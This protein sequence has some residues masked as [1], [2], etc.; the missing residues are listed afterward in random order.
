MTKNNE[1]EDGDLDNKKRKEIK[2]F[3]IWFN[4]TEKQNQEKRK[5]DL[6]RKRELEQV[7]TKSKPIKMDQK[8]LD[9][10]NLFQNAPGGS[11]MKN[12]LGKSDMQLTRQ[13]L[14]NPEPSYSPSV[15]KFSSVQNNKTVQESTPNLVQ[16][17]RPRQ[18][19]PTPL[20]VKDAVIPRTFRRSSYHP[21]SNSSTGSNQSD[22]R[23]RASLN[24]PLS[25]LSQSPL[26]QSK[27]LYSKIP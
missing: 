25:P 14:S 24:S 11:R 5:K 10:N 8:K 16:P 21:Q 15:R 12:G 13:L 19:G 7:C 6:K 1:D 20:V 17:K 4:R 26:N 3:A 2:D 22:V 9:H 18:L 27:K 23:R